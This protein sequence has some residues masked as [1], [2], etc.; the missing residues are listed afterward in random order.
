MGD[1]AN[2]VLTLDKTNYTGWMDSIKYVA[3]SKNCWEIMNGEEPC[4]TPFYS[5]GEETES[6]KSNIRNWVKRD[7]I[8]CT[9]I[10]NSTASF[11]GMS[12]VLA[13]HETSFAKFKAAQAK[14]EGF[15]ASNDHAALCQYS[16]LRFT[17]THTIET[18]FL[19]LNKILKMLRFHDCAPTDKAIVAKVITDIP[20]DY[21]TYKDQVNADLF[22]GRVPNLKTMEHCLKMREQGI[23]QNKKVPNPVLAVKP[24]NKRKFKK[25]TLICYDCRGRGHTSKY[26][27][28]SQQNQHQQNNQHQNNQ[29]PNF[30]SN[31]NNNNSNSNRNFNNNR[32]FNSNNRNFNNNNG[33]NNFNN[34]NN[35][36]FNN[37]NQNNNR[38]RPR[39][40]NNRSNRVL[41]TEPDVEINETNNNNQNNDIPSMFNAA[42]V[43]VKETKSSEWLLDSGASFHL[44]SNIENFQELE[45]LE[46]PISFTSAGDKKFDGIAKGTIH[47]ECYNGRE[48]KPSKINNVYY[49]P[50]MGNFNLFSWGQALESGCGL[51][52][53][54]NAT[55]IYNTKTK[56]KIVTADKVGNI[57]HLHMRVIKPIRHI[58]LVTQSYTLM[59]WH[60]KLGHINVH[61]IVEMS[62]SGLLPPI[63]DSSDL[64]KFTCEGCI[65]GKLARKPFKTREIRQ[66]EVGESFHTDLMGPSEIDSLCGKRYTVVCKDEMSSYRV[67]F[68]IE[69]KSEVV[70]S[71]KAYIAYVHKKTGNKVKVMRS[72]NAL[73][74]TGSS[75]EE[76]LRENNITHELSAPYVPQQNG[77]VE[78][79]NRTLTELARSMLLD[80]NV[81][82]FLWIEALSTAAYIL[83][84]VPNKKQNNISP[85][86]LWEKKKPTYKHLIK[87]GSLVYGRV[88]ESLRKKWDS[89][90]RPYISVGYTRTPENIK[91][92]CPKSNAISIIRDYKEVRNE[93][94]IN[95][96]IEQA[97][98]LDYKYCDEYEK[99]DK[100]IDRVE[101]DAIN[102]QNND[103]TES[104]DEIETNHKQ[105]ES[106]SDVSLINLALNTILKDIEPNTYEEAVASL[107][108]SKWLEAMKEE[109]N[110][111]VKNKTYDLVTLPKDKKAIECRWVFRIKRN[112]DGS[113]ERYKARLV[114]RGYAQRSGID[115]FETFS[116]VA[117]YDSI[118]AILAI[119]AQFQMH[120]VQ[121]DVKTAFLYGNLEEEIYMCQPPGF[122]DKTN[123]V[124]KLKKGLYGLKQA[125]RQ[126]NERISSFFKKHHYIQSLSDNCVYSKCDGDSLTIIV[127]YVDDGLVSSNDKS[128]LSSICNL[129]KKEFELKVHA[130]QVFVGMEITQSSDRSL[131]SI[132]QSH[133]IKVLLKRF[134]MDDC[135]PVTTPGDT[136]KQLYPSDKESNAKIPY[137]EAVGAL[138]YLAIISRPDIAF[139]VNKASQFNSKYNETHW[140]AVK[141]IFRYLKGSIDTGIHY[142]KVSKEFTL[143]GYADADY[144]GDLAVR[145][146]T[147]GF[148]VTLG[149]SAISWGSRL[150]KSV[151]QSTT[152]A[153]Y[154][155]IAE[156]TK[157]ILWYIQLFK[158]LS[159][160][161]KLPITINSDNKGAILLTQNNV[162]HKRTKHIDVRFHAIRDYQ[163]KGLIRVAFVGT[164]DQPADMFTKTLC[165]T[166]L[167][168]CKQK[169]NVA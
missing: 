94:D 68:F 106:T 55:F 74:L 159:V 158:D 111:L 117:R 143:I 37:Q 20:S 140:V 95:E 85:Y 139:Q 121:F 144:A 4:P 1:T 123:K 70:N 138:L 42:C 149:D 90:A 8:A 66:F 28:K 53:E 156:C 147:S 102:D 128:E 38:Y 56:E 80:V 167:E 6:S 9:L 69:R 43:F 157:D 46:K 52:S 29:F 162:F 93:Q 12:A 13:P 34:N 22:E 168:P 99:L 17:S 126:W 88:H 103:P 79:E 35:N 115:Y 11:E 71:L 169:I 92:Y 60:K 58:A 48:W 155:A 61:K 75:F 154:V 124:L 14:V 63:N 130:P 142:T 122:H 19:E 51:S 148:V 41:V 114:A 50:E 136:N 97:M 5:N 113:I 118:R 36:R 150:Q 98:N 64:S 78:R 135:K 145:K 2:Y 57:I 59:D 72:D 109:L 31:N 24:N 32:N 125:P 165:S 108:R 67:L 39:N 84:I 83:N 25:R 45:E 127:I 152:E 3:R 82:K 73:E 131:I 16:S 137:Q 146:S 87:F 119:T 10:I 18:Y 77:L 54:K 86:E 65:K 76:Y 104:D 120:L 30:T 89:K 112:K 129:L 164:E 27:R 26:C 141:R 62:K 15:A 91:V 47:V 116:P 132:R 151:A 40:N 160:H 134:K 33:S 105:P 100:E 49:A 96:V 7:A 44:T 161:L 107:D 110:S 133:Y 81:P 163:S 166:K 101:K 153:E 21:D 23:K